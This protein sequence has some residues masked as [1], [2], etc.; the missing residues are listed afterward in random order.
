MNDFSKTTLAGCGNPELEPSFHKSQ[1]KAAAANE[2]QEN[3]NNA[4]EPS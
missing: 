1:D 3:S 2:N 4:N